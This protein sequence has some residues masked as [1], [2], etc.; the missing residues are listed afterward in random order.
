MLA[1]LLLLMLNCWRAPST[2]LS[3]ICVRHQLRWQ[4]WLVGVLFLLLYLNFSNQWQN[5]ASTT[6]RDF[7]AFQRARQAYNT[8]STSFK[9]MPKCLDCGLQHQPTTWIKLL[10]HI[11][12]KV[13]KC[14][15]I[16]KSL[17]IG[18]TVLCLSAMILISNCYDTSMWESCFNTQY[19]AN[20]SC[21]FSGQSL[22]GNF[23]KMRIQRDLWTDFSFKLG[24]FISIL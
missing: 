4:N 10:C 23:C 11:R 22:A 21:S 24:N 12:V 20:S 13:G 18:L 1:L 17:E 15:S 6:T 19:L 8:T 16:L 5:R 3:G 14:L 7:N 9:F 2:S